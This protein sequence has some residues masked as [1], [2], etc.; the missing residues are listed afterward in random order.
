MAKQPGWLRE[1][2]ADGRLV[3]SAGG[4]WTVSGAMALEALVD[5]LK[6][7]RA[8]EVGFELS[9][10]SALDTAGVWL[11]RQAARRYE[12]TGATVAWEG[13]AERF[14]PLF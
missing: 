9:Q 6:P 5:A 1:A 4:A 12:E 2:E 3:V 10:I 14:Q 7:G 13:V 8:R 11:L